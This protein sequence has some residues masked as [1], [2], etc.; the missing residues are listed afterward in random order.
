MPDR[1][2][3][4]H[5]VIHEVLEPVDRP[6]VTFIAQPDDVT[7][8]PDVIDLLSDTRCRSSLTRS[9]SSSNRLSGTA[10]RPRRG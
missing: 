1:L 2:Q 3:A 4:E 9:A 10:P 7:G 6:L 5:E 8:L